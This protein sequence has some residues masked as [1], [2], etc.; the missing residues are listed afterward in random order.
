MR[1]VFDF[2]FVVILGKVFSSGIV[3]IV[4]G[5]YI[6]V[7]ERDVQCIK[8]VTKTDLFGNRIEVLSG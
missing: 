5:K 2:E 7:G 3:F 6:G 1:M 4:L 8:R